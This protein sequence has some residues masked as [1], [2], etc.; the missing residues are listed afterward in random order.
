MLDFSGASDIPKICCN[1]MENIPQGRPVSPLG[2][3]LNK[4]ATYGISVFAYS[5]I[6]FS[7]SCVDF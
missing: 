6:G 4:P 3:L 7:E 2:K 1:P 5:Q